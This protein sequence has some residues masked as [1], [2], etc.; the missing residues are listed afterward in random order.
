VEVAL[1]AFA[2]GAFALGM[3][4]ATGRRSTTLGV[5]SGFA[6]IGYLIDSLSRAVDGLRP[7]RPLTVWRWYDGHQP[8]AEGFDPVGMAVLLALSVAAIAIG[9]VLFERRDVRE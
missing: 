4:A 9:I 1:L 3:G 5:V 6:A 8:L 7:L 2:F